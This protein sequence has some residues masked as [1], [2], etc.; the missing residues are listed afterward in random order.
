MGGSSSSWVVV[1]E[2]DWDVLDLTLLRKP[3]TPTGNDQFSQFYAIISLSKML[4]TVQK[5]VLFILGHWVV[6]T[7]CLQ[8]EGVSV[9]SVN[10]KKPL[11]LDTSKCSDVAVPRS[12]GNTPLLIA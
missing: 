11:R 9:P 1:L 10:S 7:T 3:W 12:S 8:P 2:N 4:S 6:A 5:P